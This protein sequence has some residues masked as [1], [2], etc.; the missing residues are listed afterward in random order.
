MIALAAGMNAARSTVQDDPPSAPCEM[1]VCGAT[2]F[3]SGG[4]SS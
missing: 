3:K 1:G 4:I 2:H